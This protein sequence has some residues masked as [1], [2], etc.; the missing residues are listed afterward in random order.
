MR[1]IEFGCAGAVRG[2]I[3]ILWATTIGVF[4]EAYAV[5]PKHPLHSSG[6]VAHPSRRIVRRSPSHHRRSISFPADGFRGYIARCQKKIVILTTR[7]PHSMPVFI[8]TLLRRPFG[9]LTQSFSKSETSDVDVN[10]RVQA[11]SAAALCRVSGVPA[12]RILLAPD[13]YYVSIFSFMYA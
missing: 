9:L 8:W 6:L 1:K 2:G 4:C 3:R 7:S 10:L 5:L 13:S 12:E 11:G